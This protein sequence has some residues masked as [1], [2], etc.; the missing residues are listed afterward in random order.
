VGLAA[1]GVSQGAAWGWADER[2][3]A[4]LAGGG[5]A[6]AAALGRSRRHPA[7]AIET[8]LWRSRPFALANVASL[9]YGA[10]L[11]AWLLCAMLFLTQ[12]WD[13]RPLQAGLAVSPGAVVA[14]VVAL[15]C[16]PLV[17][18]FGPRPVIVSGAVA[19]IAVAV[20][21]GVA[22]PQQP[23]FLGF[24]LPVGTLVGVGMGAVT[25]GTSAA[26]ALSV[27][28][29]RFAAAVG[30]NQTARQVGGALG[31]ATLATMLHTA[32]AGSAATY[33]HVFLFCA[34]ATAASALA[35]TWLVLR[36]AE[37]TA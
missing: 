8:S 28:P 34:I 22:V 29:Q 3:L 33:R 4:A 10:C 18:R 37:A 13:Y 15:R 16:G 31:V 11:F 12:V 25:T 1:L 26:A 19:L 5:V 23:D 24:W 32:D 36:P 9:F 17:A 2:T 7:P 6:I 27:A 35:A 20:V 21:M 30:L 14:T